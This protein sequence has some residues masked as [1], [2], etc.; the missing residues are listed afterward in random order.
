MPTYIPAAEA[1]AKIKAGERVA[2]ESLD[3][4]TRAYVQTALW[5]SNDESDPETG[6]EPLDR[7]HG[8]E[9]I[10]P[11]TQAGMV[12]DCAKFQEDNAANLESA[13]A[14]GAVKCGPDFDE[15]GRAGH[16]FWLTREHHG[17][18][19][20]DGDWPK[21]YGDKLTVAAQAFGEHGLYL[22]DDGLIYQEGA[23]RLPD[24]T[25]PPVTMTPKQA[26][27]YAAQ[28]GSAVRGGDPGACMYGFD[29]RF[30]I[31]SPEHGRACLAWI[32][33]HCTPEAGEVDKPRLACLAGMIRAQLPEV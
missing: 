14:T 31:Q 8:W 13:I 19:F 4:F 23:E 22:G 28:W 6:G 9:D 10:A 24:G 3:T 20:W 11:A 5:S 15:W 7:N 21:P 2:L 33:S 17:A 29:E 25:E 16:D 18:G 32:E 12:L 26:W 27:L 30:A 1:V